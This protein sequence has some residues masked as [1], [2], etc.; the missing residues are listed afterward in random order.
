MIYW[1]GSFGGFVGVE[2][3]CGRGG[4]EVVGG[5]DRLAQIRSG[6]APNLYNQG[7]PDDNHCVC[8]RSIRNMGA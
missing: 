7:R 6:V 8:S 5:V 1:E 3:D 2:L 4:F